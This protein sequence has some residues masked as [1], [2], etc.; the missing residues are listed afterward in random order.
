MLVTAVGP[1][2]EWGMIMDKV[3]GSDIEETPLQEKLGVRLLPV[4]AAGYK[5]AVSTLLWFSLASCSI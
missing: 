3:T 5:G 4:T 2:S 1:N